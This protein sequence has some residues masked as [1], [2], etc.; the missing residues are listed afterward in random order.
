M[1]TEEIVD[2][3]GRIIYIFHNQHGGMR[4]THQKED[5]K[6]LYRNE[7]RLALKL[8]LFPDRD[9]FVSDVV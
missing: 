9:P 7:A 5:V 3:V 8:P 1:I 6:E 2:R 4:W